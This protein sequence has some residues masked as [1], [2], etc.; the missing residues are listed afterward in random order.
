M[1]ANPP[2]VPKPEDPFAKIHK[3]LDDI[4]STIE[5]IPVGAGCFTVFFACTAAIV[6]A[7]ILALLIIPRLNP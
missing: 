2:P 7:A 6:C 1:D 5:N 3:R 4:E